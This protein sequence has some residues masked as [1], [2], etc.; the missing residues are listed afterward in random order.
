MNWIRFPLQ[1]GIDKTSPLLPA[2]HTFFPPQ[3]R[4]GKKGKKGGYANKPGEKKGRKKKKEKRSTKSQN[5][6]PASLIN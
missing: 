4:V 3:Q 6:L 5:R 2:P 1:I